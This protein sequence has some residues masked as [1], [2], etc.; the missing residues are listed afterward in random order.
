MSAPP[1]ANKVKVCVRCKRDCSS[2]P[3]LKNPQGQYICRDCYD[4]DAL[5]LKDRPVRSLSDPVETGARADVSNPDHATPLDEIINSGEGLGAGLGANDDVEIQVAPE[6]AQ[7]APSHAHA[8]VDTARDPRM[9]SSCGMV[10]HH[11]AVI[12][13][14]CGMNSKTGLFLTGKPAPAGN[15]CVQCGYDM[16]GLPSPRCPEC[17]TINTRSQRLKHQPTEQTI[18]DNYLRP[19]IYAALGLAISVPIVGLS[20]GWSAV[21]PHLLHTLGAV[22]AGVIA[23][24]ICA[25]IWLGLEAPIPV[26]AARMAGVVCLTSAAS[27]FG[28]L[29]PFLVLWIVFPV[30]VYVAL[31]MDLFDIDYSDAAIITL[32]SVG[33]WTGMWFAVLRFI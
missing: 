27:H 33:V 14:A 16:R 26:I 30:V 10:M 8:G 25:I 20:V 4:R 17:G 24:A 11:D 32:V 5:G 21:G 3:R 1:W 28:G 18:R 19:A 31:L 23:F 6:D 12:C 9:C 2:I 7:H 29:V 22:V 15:A 13:M